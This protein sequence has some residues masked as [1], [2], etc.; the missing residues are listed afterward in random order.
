MGVKGFEAGFY[1]YVFI[2]NGSVISVDVFSV[3][4]TDA[5]RTRVYFFEGF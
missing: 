3:A 4:I 2:T 5:D 1:T